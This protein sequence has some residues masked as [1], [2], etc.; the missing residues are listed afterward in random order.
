VVK[1]FRG[2]SISGAGDGAVVVGS[3]GTGQSATA[4]GGTPSA[5]GELALAAFAT[6]STSTGSGLTTSTTPSGWALAGDQADSLNTDGIAAWA[7]WKTGTA[8]APTASLSW[9]NTGGN[10]PYTTAITS[11]AKAPSTVPTVTGVS[12]ISGTTTGA[13][14]VSVTGTN[15]TGATTVKFGSTKAVNFTVNSATSITAAAPS[16]PAGTVDVTVTTSSGTSVTSSADKFSF[17]PNAVLASGGSLSVGNSVRSSTGSYRLTL[18]GDGNL[19]EYNA[20]NTP[21]WA[22]G[23]STGTSAV[24]QGDGNLV[25]YNATNAPLWASNTS[26]HPGAYLALTDAGLLSVDAPTGQPLWAGPGLLVAGA[27]LGAG[28]SLSSPGGSY[29]LT[30]QGDGNLVEYNATNTPVWA[31]GTSAGTSAVMQGD[32]NLVVYNASNTPLWASNTSEHPGAYLALTDAGL[33]AVE[34]FAS[35]VLTLHGGS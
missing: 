30:M 9:T 15:F 13:T 11:L 6:D 33:L 27:S 25:V 26:G 17:E 21:V 7:Y 31:A 19:V 24:M 14:S 35:V 22:A 12:P 28:Q 32:G 20:T 8:S 18:Q 23:T 29:R 1:E 34:A 3:G 4:T 2:A 5:S 10:V 16:E